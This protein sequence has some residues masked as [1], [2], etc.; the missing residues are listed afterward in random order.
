MTQRSVSSSIHVD[1]SEPAE[2][3]LLRAQLALRN[4]ALD[5]AATHFMIV[6]AQSSPARIAFVN[7]AL[8][9][10]HGY[11]PH[12]LIGGDPARLIAIQDCPDGYAKLMEAIR[13]GSHE[14]VQ[15][16][17]RRRD[18]TTFWAGVAVSA[19]RNERNDVTHFVVVGTDITRKLEDERNREE[20]QHRL[21][22]EMKERERM[23]VEL[24]F[25]QKL[26]AVGQLAAG[27]THEIN[28]PVQYIGDSVLFLQSAALDI[29]VSSRPI[30]PSSPHFQAEMH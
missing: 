11:Q 12:E 10:A 24:R 3:E 28:T 9:E 27:I 4:C 15:L 16:R 17:S 25:A 19:V 22:Q 29:N 20:L 8:A 21:L 2:L 1:Y 26:E 23:A 5:A 30:G 14:R 7:R 13:L 18:G 6:E